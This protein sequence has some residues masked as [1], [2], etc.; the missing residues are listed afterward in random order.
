MFVIIWGTDSG[1]LDFKILLRDEDDAQGLAELLR[2]LQLPETKPA[3][4]FTVPDIRGAAY[5]SDGT[6]GDEDVF[7]LEDEPDLLA[8][9]S[10]PPVL[11][12]F[13]I[14]I[15]ASD[16]GRNDAY[17]A[18]PGV[19]VISGTDPLDLAA[20]VMQS[21]S[22]RQVRTQLFDANDAA[23]MRQLGSDL[24]VLPDSFA[25][26]AAANPRQDN[27]RSG[28]ES[29]QQGDL[30]AA[31]KAFEEAAASDH[32][33]SA[34]L[35]RGNVLTTMAAS[36][37]VPESDD[38]LRNRAISA[39]QA[40]ASA[41]NADD[42]VI[43]D[44]ADELFD[45]HAY[46]AA[47]SSYE[48]YLR[49]NPDDL[50]VRM[51]LGTAFAL[52][53]NLPDEERYNSARGEYSAIL[54]RDPDHWNARRS[55]GIVHFYRCDYQSALFDLKIAIKQKPRSAGAHFYLALAFYALSD[56][57]KALREVDKAIDDATPDDRPYWYEYVRAIVLGNLSRDRDALAAAS[58]SLRLAAEGTHMELVRSAKTAIALFQYRLRSPDRALE[59]LSSIGDEQMPAEAYALR[60][61]ILLTSN[62]L[63]NAEAAIN[64]AVDTIAAAMPSCAQVGTYWPIYLCQAAVLNAIA[65]RD[66]GVGP[67][68]REANRATVRAENDLQL[69]DLDSFNERDR[70][71]AAQIFLQRAHANLILDRPQLVTSALKQ[72]RL[73]APKGS[74]TWK[75]AVRGLRETERVQPIRPSWIVA[76]EA[77]GLGGAVVLLLFGQL[78]STTFATLALGLPVLGIAAYVLPSLTKL[79]VAGAVEIERVVASASTTVDQIPPPP[80]LPPFPAMRPREAPSDKLPPP[81]QPEPTDAAEA[82]APSLGRLASRSMRAFHR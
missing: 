82:S 40:A 59:T 80:P 77:L 25:E 1:H 22:G 53:T 34:D 71:T 66:D 31:L 63:L 33:G 38:E 23:L 73:Y 49:R 35:M 2:D 36:P 19:H 16:I 60:A 61:H 21:Y 39:F 51:A 32:S 50:G 29:F 37:G 57:K 30:D 14:G 48:Q 75:A 8:A 43:V 28:M 42:S 72:C 18:L 79:K 10:E 3:A 64:K 69:V 68:A 20:E 55:R 47:R 74:A 78:D 5:F 81:Y 27:F 56:P 70:E 24:P 26:E 76:C 12:T 11:S 41:S 17:R 4:T 58:R 65:R 6:V 7:V 62:D 54:R 52:D 9:I 67:E 44:A 45:L 46:A 15:A 13:Y